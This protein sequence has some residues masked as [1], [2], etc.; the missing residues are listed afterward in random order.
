MHV[1]GQD[2]SLLRNGS[3]DTSYWTN[4]IYIGPGE[5][6]DVLINA[7][8]YSASR[9]SGSDRARELQRVLPQVPRLRHLS[10]HGAGR[11]RRNDDRGPRLPE[12]A[13]LARRK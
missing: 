1:A 5:A 10:N 13:F 6:R 12:R 8:A 2:A 4:T 7:P 9:P 3:V 11:T